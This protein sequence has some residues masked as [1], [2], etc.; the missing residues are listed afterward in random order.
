MPSTYEIRQLPVWPELQQLRLE[1]R[2]SR[3]KFWISIEEEP[4]LWLLKYPRPNTGEHWAEKIAAEVGRLIDVDCARVEL[5]NCDGELTTIC[6]SFDP[7]NWY[8]LY[9]Y[10]VAERDFID[11]DYLR[12]ADSEWST[13]VDLIDIEGSIFIPGSEILAS[14]IDGYDTSPEA[15]FRQR[16]HNVRNIIKAVKETINGEDHQARQDLN[17]VLNSLASYAVLDGLI[18]NMDRHHE[19]WEIKDEISNGV[20][21]F[22]VAPSYDHASSLGRELHDQSRKRILHSNGI[23]NY[24]RRGH[25]GVF[26]DDQQNRAPSPLQTAKYISQQW[27][28]YTQPTLERIGETPDSEFR[29]AIDRVPTEFMGDIAK[30]FAYQIIVTRKTELLKLI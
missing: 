20:R 22:S 14:K 21:R 27:P 2:G 1:S 12:P 29:T 24:L 8:E 15:R 6:E 23:L 26:G 30:E 11:D 4:K 3:H 13:D 10:Y 28:E 18:G 17:R 7:D 19:N 25:G 5:A 16:D 9:E